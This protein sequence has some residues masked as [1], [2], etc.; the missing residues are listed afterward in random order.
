MP[1]ERLL[2][3]RLD[4]LG[5]ATAALAEDEPVVLIIEHAIAPRAPVATDSLVER[6]A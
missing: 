1:S 2:A 6:V 4:L 5:L 3:N